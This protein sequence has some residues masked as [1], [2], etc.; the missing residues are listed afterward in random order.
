MNTV[1]TTGLS[2]KQVNTVDPINQEQSYDA[3]LNN[4]CAALSHHL[5]LVAALAWSV[6]L[7]PSEIA[8]SVHVEE[9][10]LGRV[11]DVHA[12]IEV[13]AEVEQNVRFTFCTQVVVQKLAN[14]DGIRL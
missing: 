5:Y 8:A 2:V 11:P 6:A 1:I 14:L 13:A 12:D 3:V 10:G 4:Q 9:V 7:Q